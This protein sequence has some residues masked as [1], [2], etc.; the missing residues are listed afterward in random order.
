M[1]VAPESEIKLDW[2]VLLLLMA[3]AVGVEGGEEER[4]VST[5]RLIKLVH[6]QFKCAMFKLVHAKVELSMDITPCLHLGFQVGRN[7]ALRVVP[8]M[9]LALVAVVWWPLLES[10]ILQSE[11]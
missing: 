1:P 7:S 3:K 2:V 6:V 9:V 10:L 5:E 8:P 4:G 11:L